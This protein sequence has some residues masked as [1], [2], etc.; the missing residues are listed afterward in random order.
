MLVLTYIKPKS[1][2]LDIFFILR[3][4]TYIHRKFTVKAAKSIFF[5]FR[6]LN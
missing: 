6:K 5:N 4:R 3:K 1:Y 2:I